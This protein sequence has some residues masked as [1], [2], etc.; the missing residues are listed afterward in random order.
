MIKINRALIAEV[1]KRLPKNVNPP[2]TLDFL[3]KQKA[4]EKI[5]HKDNKIDN[6]LVNKKIIENFIKN[7]SSKPFS[8]LKRQLNM[9]Q[10]IIAIK[11]KTINISN[12][13]K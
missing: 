3:L 9:R 11:R 10:S 2:I 13:N 6:N 8:S 1:R 12:I 4:V 5:E 7:N